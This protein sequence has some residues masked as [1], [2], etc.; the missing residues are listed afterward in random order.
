M[1][2]LVAA[3]PLAAQEA[4]DGEGDQKT[5]APEAQGVPFSFDILSE[6]MARAAQEDQKE[7][8]QVEG[9]LAELD[10]DGYQRIR[11][12]KDQARWADLPDDTFRLQAFHLGW[13][14]KQP[15]RLHEVVDGHAKE[16]HFSTSDF[17]YSDVKTEIPADAEMPG[18]AGFRLH[19]PLNRADTFDELV[20]FLGASYFR[21]LGRG[22][23]YGLSARG[24]AVNTGLSGVE[25]F[26]RFDNFWLERPGP[27][28]E[29]ITIYAALSSA[30]V[31]GAYRFVVRPGEDTRIDVTARLYLRNDIQQLGIAPLTSM[32]LFGGPDMGDFDDFRPAVHDSEALVLT[33][34]GGETFFRPLNNPPR[35]ASSYFG[36]LSPVKFGLV[37]RNREFEHYLDAQAHYEKRPTLLVEP[38]GDWGEGSV[39]LVEIPS[40]L[41]GNDNIV[42]FW[43]PKAETKAG[44]A[45]EFA[46]RLHWGMSPEGDGAVDRARVVRTR[47][48]KGGISGT[49]EDNGRRKFV[50]DFEGGTL[51]ELPAGAEVEPSVSA[52]N[53]EI[54]EAVVS[55]IS[56]TETWRLVLE[57][58]APDG[59]V[60]ELKAGLKGYGRTLTETW[61]Y[62]WVKE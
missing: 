37:Q 40:D 50:I 60:A 35:L 30:S 41:E 18:V 44:D 43:I 34:Q 23:L 22:N 10:Y 62:Q 19:N 7:P 52:A 54:A 14:F 6:Q 15:V 59:A 45:L 24:L 48:G 53:G 61:T 56:G 12:D 21:A 2:A 20:A 5:N 3:G 58:E 13:L 9:F 27:G 25:E 47:V 46:Y 29:H 55:R 32:F 1:P 39:R 31:T 16:M 17:D 49:D 26:P 8:E 36:A 11:F 38:I 57:V 42:A 33:T 28:A 4:A 51:G